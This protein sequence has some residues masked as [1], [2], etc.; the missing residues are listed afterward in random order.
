MRKLPTYAL[1]FASGLAALSWEVLWQ[2]RASL[3]IGVSAM[4]T[5]VT[6]AA[7]M[8]GM[9]LGALVMGRVLAGDSATSRR[10]AARPLRIYAALE[11][12]IG[13]AGVLVFLPGFALLER[14]DGAIFLRA[15]TAATLVQLLGMFVVVGLPTLA[16]GATVPVFGLMARASRTRIAALYGVNTA[17]AATGVL[18]VTFG[19]MPRLGVELTAM[20]MT[21]VNMLVALA[22][23]TRRGDAAVA[24]PREATEASA[25]AEAL[26]VPA[27]ALGPVMDEHSAAWVAFLTGFVSFGLEVAWFRTLRASFRSTTDAFAVMLV[28]VLVPLAF[29]AKLGS[30][31]R[32]RGTRMSSVLAAAGAAVLVVTPVIERFDVLGSRPFRSVWSMC[33]AWLGGSLP[34]LGLPMLLLGTCLPWLLDSAS[35]A[36]SG[37][38]P[39]SWGRLYAMNTIGAVVGSLAAAWLLLPGLGFARTAWLLGALVVV[40]SLFVPSFQLS[41]RR[42]APGALALI[43]AVL[44]ESGAG[45]TRIIGNFSTPLA[46]IVT[47]DEG[48]DA[49]L[50]VADNTSGER[51]LFIDGF[52]ATNESAAAHYMAW[53]GRLP[54]I[55]HAAPRRALVICF[56]TGQTANG[57][58]RE[59]PESLDVVDLS[60]AVL[61]AG[62][63]FAKNE[64]VLDDPRVHATVMD[65]R[66]W[67][68]RTDHVYDVVTLEPMPPNFAGVNAL[69][70]REFYE[71]VASRLAEGGVAAQWLPYHLLS[72]HDAVAIVAT[73]H[74]VFGDSLV[75]VDPVVQTGIIV[76]RRAS[77]RKD[78]ARAWPG[79]ARSSPGRDLDANAV[80][81]AVALV[82]PDVTRLAQLGEI[83][84]DDNQLLAYGPSRYRLS[85]APAELMDANMAVMERVRAQGAGAAK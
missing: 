64:G 78:L 13:L 73:F 71:L 44:A 57:V 11:I 8:G 20:A 42:L 74:S 56:G 39:A 16:M 62:H 43:V 46:R 9:T 6:L 51:L 22:A 10:A 70:S 24:P 66:A 79:L 32:A 84:T 52:V 40:A 4:G 37:R 67:L 38:A 28:S 41:W 33:L 72:V 3:A 45:R 59:G 12:V 48:V 36:P 47:F 76:G 85:F 21:S 55:L 17:G 58:R 75:W 7:T 35:G 68:R 25:A 63:L 80:L 29:G 49:T 53:M 1:V 26:E 61:R 14:I 83:I 27:R 15:P 34:V 18:V 31:L 19:L 54:M 77:A 65:G 50:A 23:W 81:R 30:W 2:I 60:P 82:P 5:A 69:Y